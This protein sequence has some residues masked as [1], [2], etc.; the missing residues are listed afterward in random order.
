MDPFDRSG[1]QWIEV[2]QIDRKDRIRLNGV[3]WAKWTNWTKVVVDQNELNGQKQTKWMKQTEVEQMDE[4]D[5]IGPNQT[6]V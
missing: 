6:E 4:V 5:C 1:L 3:K 2:Y